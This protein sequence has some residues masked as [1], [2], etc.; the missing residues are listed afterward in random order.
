[1][2]LHDTM[3]LDTFAEALRPPPRVGLWNWSDDNIHLPDDAAEKGKYRSSRTPFNRDIMDCLNPWNPIEEVYVVKGR[4]VGCTQIMQNWFGY[5]VVVD[6]N[7][8]VLLQPTATKAQEFGKVRINKTIINSPALRR[9]INPD[10]SRSSSNTL[11]LKEFPGGFLYLLGAESAAA[12]RGITCGKLGFDEVDGYKHDVKGEGDVISNVVQM[13]TTFARMKVFAI[14]TPTDELSLIYQMFEQTDQRHLY[15]PCPLCGEMQVLSWAGIKFK[16]VQ[17]RLESDV[18]YKCKHC[19]NEFYEYHKDAMLAAYEWRPHAPFDGKRAGFFLPAFNSP[20]GWYS[21]TKAVTSFL[22]FKRLR[23]REKQKTWT[24]HVCAEKFRE[25]IKEIKTS[26][27]LLRREYYEKVV[28]AAVR[29]LTVGVDIQK[30]R[31]ELEIIAWALGLESWSMM[32]KVLLGDTLY[33]PVWAE[34]D[35]VLLQSWPREDGAVLVPARTGLDTGY[36]TDQCYDFIRSRQNYVSAVKGAKEADQPIV[37]KYT[38]KDKGRIYLHTVGTEQ[39][40]DMI[41]SYLELS[42]PGP[43]FMHFNQEHDEDYFNGLNSEYAVFER[44]ARRY[45]K[46]LGV[47]RNEPLDV[48]VY[49]TAALHLLMKHTGFTLDNIDTAQAPAAGPQAPRG[50]RVRGRGA[51]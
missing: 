20:L 35:K 10:A 26:D 51:Q 23:S 48:R 47:E 25:V 9:L 36:R 8:I 3:V 18:T 30:D 1:M 6:P 49:G 13:A 22:E 2:S 38:K 28:P 4:Q 44:G 19:K 21:W 40:K 15:V 17:Y 12:I 16:H 34:L 50:R 24:N 39:T 37:D 42:E 27:L 29:V 45:K 11:T 41:Y 33:K 5:N 14:S 7:T 43:G 31:I 46:K 32:Y